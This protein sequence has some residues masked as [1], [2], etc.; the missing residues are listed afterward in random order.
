MTTTRQ[1]Y[2]NL[3]RNPVA[4]LFIFDPA[5]PLRTLEIRAD[6]ELVPDRDKDLLPLFAKQYGVDEAMLDIP[7]SER[8]T[9]T[10]TPSES[11]PSPGG[12][13]RGPCPPGASR[14]GGGAPIPAARP[15]PRPQATG[16]K[17]CSSFTM[18]CM[19]EPADVVTRIR[20]GA[21]SALARH[22]LRKLSMT[23]VSTEAGVSRGTLYRYF[24]TRAE[25][26]DS[27]A[28]HAQEIFERAIAE[29]VAAE[30][31]LDDRVRVVIEA[32]FDFGRRP[33]YARLL[34]LEP[35]LVRDFV[36]ERFDKL[37]GPV[38]KALAPAATDDQS[39]LPWI[40]PWSVAEILLRLSF[41][42]A[43]VKAPNGLRSVGLDEVIDRLL[44]RSAAGRG[45]GAAPGADGELW[46]DMT[47][48]GS[49]DEGSKTLGRRRTGADK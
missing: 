23:D 39:E 30:P 38:A 22:G 42:Y 12:D 16:N 47:A 35:N 10:S 11:S 49:G 37:V 6:V 26:L 28:D 46:A 3:L 34:D 15:A 14:A 29:R 13:G 18:G 40:D 25:L 7:G 32:V 43:Q 41:S 45:L 1:K 9:A 20:E 33:S 24:A 27:L 4:S 31:A 44:G 5:N 21:L 17:N 48:L 36:N 2:K 8:M 19:R